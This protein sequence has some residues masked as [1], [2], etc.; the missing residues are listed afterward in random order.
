MTQPPIADAW[1]ER[2]VDDMPQIA[3]MQAARRIRPVEYAGD[4]HFPPVANGVD[5]LVSVVELLQRE[6]G[7]ASARDLKYAVLHLAAG[8]EVLL[9]ARLFMEHWSLVFT[10]PGAATRAALED[11]SLSSCSPDQ[12]RKRLKN[13][14]GISFA[15]HEEQALKDI[16]AKRNSL[17]HWGLVGDQASAASVTSTTATVLNFL[18]SFVDEHLIPEL[19]EPERSAAELEMEHVRDGLHYIEEYVRE[20]MKDLAPRLGPVRR[21]TVRCPLCGQWA[22]IVPGYSNAP[23]ADSINDTYNVECLFCSATLNAVEA[24]HE[25]NAV[26]L[27]RYGEAE[28]YDGPEGIYTCPLCPHGLLVHGVSTAADRDRP[29]NF[30]FA[31]ATEFDNPPPPALHRPGWVTREV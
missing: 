24:A 19:K 4:P 18:V 14:V 7:P 26:I 27:G 28:E 22:L 9:K 10:D 16:A 25:Y 23:G 21:T 20:R 12:T 30:C 13:I 6:E 5:Y 2:P 8:T 17:Q 1:D 11:G 15:G 31:C 29:V 3:R